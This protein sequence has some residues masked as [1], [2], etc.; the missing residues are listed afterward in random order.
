MQGGC[1][2]ANIIHISQV[3]SFDATIITTGPYCVF[4]TSITLAA[5]DPGGTWSGTG[6][7][8]A[9]TGTFNPSAAGIGSHQV[10]YQIPGSCG[11][12]D[13]ALIMVSSKL[14]ATI[15]P[16]GA[17]CSNLA[18]FNLTAASAG[19]NWSGAGIISPSLGTF[20]PAVADTGIHI[21]M[22][23]ISGQCGDSDTVA[24]KV[25][26]CEVTPVIYVPNIFSPNGDN[27]NDILYVRGQA[28][29]NLEF[30]IYDRW[31]EKVFETTDQTKGWDG[32]FR[33]KPMD[34]AVYFWHLK[35]TLG[36]DKQINWKG[37]LTLVR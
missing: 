26:S 12:A 9:T 16:V 36:I 3:S 11:D 10:I 14:N 17:V 6:I 18:P 4:D 13:T 30:I 21:I 25:I 33:G 34:E 1:P 20:S 28:I 37:S 27:I 35:A 19:G 29:S 31:G 22:Y 5:V 8:N 23:A 24:V 7:T 15:N 2:G 32:T